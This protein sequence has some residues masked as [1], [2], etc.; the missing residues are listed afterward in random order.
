MGC[1]RGLVRIDR[2]HGGSLIQAFALPFQ[3]Q[4][5]FGRCGID[6]ISHRELTARGDDE[7]I[8]LFLLQH[9][10]LHLHIVAGMAPV[11]LGVHVAQ[12]EAGRQTQQ[13]A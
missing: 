6:E 13:D 3:A 8:G 4:A 12:I 10:P 2:L 11:T 1:Q 7:I 9:E 5:Q